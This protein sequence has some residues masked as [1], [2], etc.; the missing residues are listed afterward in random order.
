MYETGDDILI[1]DVL[2]F[3]V[4]AAWFAN[5]SLLPP[6]ANAPPPPPFLFETIRPGSSPPADGC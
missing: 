1:T 3:E 4:K 5:Q 2:S 6:Q